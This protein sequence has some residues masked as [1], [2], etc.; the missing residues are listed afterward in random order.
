MG[1]AV[2]KHFKEL[3]VSMDWENPEWRNK[4]WAIM[5]LS[6]FPILQRLDEAG[7]VPDATTE[8][9]ADVGKAIKEV[10]ETIERDFG[11]TSMSHVVGCVSKLMG[12]TL[13]PL[14]CDIL[15][16]LEAEGVK[17]RNITEII[18]VGEK[19]RVK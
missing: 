4:F 1:R 7:R 16:K 6:A 15:E 14:H 12:R 10:L 13:G 19:V 3:Q 5:S 18:V 11:R 17:L 2:P 9:K 8:R